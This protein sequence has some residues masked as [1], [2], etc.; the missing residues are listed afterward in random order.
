MYIIKNI[1]KGFIE[2]EMGGFLGKVLAFI[3]AGLFIPVMVGWLVGSLL[4]YAI[5]SIT[6]EILLFLFL[7]FVVIEIAT[8]SSSTYIR[9][10]ATLTTIIF[11]FVVIV[12]LTNIFGAR[13]EILQD[14]SGFING[15]VKWNW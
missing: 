7:L 10:S 13:A 12:L 3:I 6:L 5:P 11:F 9:V 4:A 14:L 2:E 8:K 1:K 15:P